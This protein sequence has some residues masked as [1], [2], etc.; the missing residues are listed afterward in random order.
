MQLLTN[1][2]NAEKN[3]NQTI[4]RVEKM[5]ANFGCW[6]L[7]NGPFPINC[8]N[9]KINNGFYWFEV[10][11]FREVFLRFCAEQCRVWCSKINN[12]IEYLWKLSRKQTLTQC[13]VLLGGHNIPAFHASMV[14]VLI[15]IN[16]DSYRNACQSQYSLWN[17]ILDQIMGWKPHIL[18]QSAYSVECE[19]N[20]YKRQ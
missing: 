6:S 15:K 9:Q 1:R 16:R 18:S 20:E 17:Y 4:T 7:I 5:Y 19:L 10:I 13:V 11:F 8:F 12:M 3:I 2:F 14:G